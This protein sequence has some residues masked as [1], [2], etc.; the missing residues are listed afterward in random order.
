MLG[1]SKLE[2]TASFVRSATAS[3]VTQQICHENGAFRKLRPLNRRNLKTHA[4]CFGVKGKN[5]DNGAFL[6]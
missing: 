4:F 1:P 2:N 6:K 5:F 3:F